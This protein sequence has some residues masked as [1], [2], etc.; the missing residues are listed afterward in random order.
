MN[1]PRALTGA[2]LFAGLAAVWPAG[3]ASG[4]SPP[5]RC[6]LEVAIQPEQPLVGE[7]VLY[8]L[9][10]LR[11]L[12]VSELRWERPLTF[13]TMRAEWLPGRAADETVVRSGETYR[14]YSERRALFPVH[15][16]EQALPGA[17]V[18]CTTPSGEEIVE[19]PRRHLSAKALPEAGRPAD[20]QGIVGP[21]RLS[22]TTAPEAI[23][24]GE[25]VRLSIVARGTGNLW[26]VRPRFVP[27]LEPD[28]FEVFA[29]PP[30]T[31]RD[32]GR[33]LSVRRYFAFDLVPRRAGTL[34][35]PRVELDFFDPETGRYEVAHADAGRI[36]VA[37]ARARMPA[38]A[39]AT[40]LRIAPPPPP[41]PSGRR[42]ILPAAGGIV[43]A[44]VALGVWLRR[45][46]A[47][48]PW[49]EVERLAAIARAGETPE[50][51]ARAA[52]AALRTA[53]A[54]ALPE[55]RALSAEEL[56]ARAPG[57]G[58]PHAAAKLVSRIE[59]A[60]FAGTPDAGWSTDDLDHHLA[61]LRD[62]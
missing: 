9:R 39:A 24:L 46:R 53:L 58:A 8:S 57:G 50:E 59:S 7:Q 3:P 15:P 48:D 34:Q 49:A 6:R 33:S 55:A 51:R 26:T 4:G 36:S 23:A 12:D 60:R 44:I 32:V 28:E 19:V 21:V 45:R 42:W 43:A 56:I 38:P 5:P 22:V 35:L 52:G 17:A 10:I 16:G 31:A 1:T 27:E 40:P 14:V 18:Q 20:F 2:A 13:P 62:C 29:R 61:A 37:P 25:S 11:R 54:R 41:Q 47:P 30:E